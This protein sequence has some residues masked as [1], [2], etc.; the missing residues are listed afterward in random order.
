MSMLDER[1]A[2]EAREAR[3]ASCSIIVEKLVGESD[4]GGVNAVAVVDVTAHRRD[5]F[6]AYICRA[7][8]LSTASTV[9]VVVGAM[10]CLGNDASG[11]CAMRMDDAEQPI[12]TSQCCIPYSHTHRIA[13]RILCSNLGILTT[14]G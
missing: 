12:L 9:S 4:R 6:A 11:S 7:V 10:V 5:C 2:R 3:V 14:L 1:E 13:Q 8:I